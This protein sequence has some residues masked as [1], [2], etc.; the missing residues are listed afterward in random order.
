MKTLF[1]E[2]RKSGLG[3]SDA[4]AAYN[5]GFSCGRKKYYEVRGITPDF[6]KDVSP[7]LE[8]GT[9]IEPVIKLMYEKKTGRKVALKGLMRSA[10]YPYM[11]VHMD[12][13][14]TAPDKPGEGYVEFKCVNRFIF[15]K[16]QKEGIRDEYILQMQHGLAVTGYQWGSYGVLCLDPWQFAY[17]DVNRD[18][19]LIDKLI[20]DEGILWGKIENGP[21]PDPLPDAKDKRCAT[22]QWR[23]TCRAADLVEGLPD[24]SQAEG[25]LVKRADLVPLLV[26]LTELRQLKDEATE[27]YDDATGKLKA[28]IGTNYGIQLPGY[29]CLMPTSYPERWD[30]KAL[31]GLRK[32]ANTILEREREMWDYEELENR[33]TELMEIVIALTKAKKPP[34]PERSLRIYATGD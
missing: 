26:E 12:G 11:I 10:D 1:D 14:T 34:K 21:I 27:L 29:R 33:I 13:V 18:Q 6:S 25:E 8:R 3:G 17:F 2:E 31:E 5:M 30:T 23:R 19:E 15:K 22:C 32:D 16:F 7:E 28:E 4:A 20:V 9:L 24:S